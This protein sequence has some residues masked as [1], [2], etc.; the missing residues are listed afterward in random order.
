MVIA[1]NYSCLDRLTIEDLQ[2]VYGVLAK[3]APQR[4]GLERLLTER[5]HLVSIL[6]NPAL[7][8]A[9]VE[10]PLLVHASPHLYFYLLVRKSLRE[11]GIDDAEVADYI[12]AVLAERA[13]TPPSDPLR[14]I[15]GG[16]LHAVDFIAMIEQADGKTRFELLVAAGNQFLVLTGI[17][18]DF[19]K[20]RSERR[21]APGVGFYEGFARDSYAEASRHPLADPAGLG[22]VLG[23][24]SDHLPEARRTLNRMADS[25]LFLAN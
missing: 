25:L 2:F 19:V 12:A 20:R 1:E 21:G 11:A 16:F 6:D 23:S 10:R 7:H 15:P 4:D 9:M 18:P 17:F 3:N 14:G 5:C 24:L 8:R 13:T 22:D